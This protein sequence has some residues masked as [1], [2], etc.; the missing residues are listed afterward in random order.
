MIVKPFFCLIFAT[1]TK[2]RNDIMTQLMAN[3]IYDSAFKYMMQNERAV[4]VLLENLL[5]KK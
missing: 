3:P 2:Q 5:G 1:N 4:T